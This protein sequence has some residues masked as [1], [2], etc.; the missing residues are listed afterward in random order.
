M[1][2]R[3]GCQWSKVWADNFDTRPAGWWGKD[4]MFCRRRPKWRGFFA[5]K[6]GPLFWFSPSAHIAVNGAVYEKS[7]IVSKRGSGGGQWLDKF[8]PFS[9]T[10]HDGLPPALHC[11]LFPK[12]HT[13]FICWIFQQQNIFTRLSSMQS[14]LAR[15][16]PQNVYAWFHNVMQWDL[17]WNLSFQ[18]RL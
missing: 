11:N 10:S 13:N 7:S 15:I 16:E 1:L 12:K 2:A 17:I 9:N 4:Y 5:K 18:F 6:I 3:G 8:S 14:M